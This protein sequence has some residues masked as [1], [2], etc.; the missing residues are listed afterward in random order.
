MIELTLSPYIIKK[1]HEWVFG[2]NKESPDRLYKKLKEAVDNETDVDVKDILNDIFDKLEN[3]VVGDYFKLDKIRKKFDEDIIKIRG[4]EVIRDI[5]IS[6]KD[7]DGKD[8][9]IG[10]KEKKLYEILKKIFVESEYKYFYRSSGWNA[11]LFHQELNLSVCPYCGTQF[12]FLSYEAGGKTRATL[13]HFFD[14]ATYPFLGISVYNLIP[15][16]KVCNYD[17]KGSVSMNL[18][19]NYIPYEKGIVN[20]INFELDNMTNLEMKEK[21]ANNQEIDYYNMF[22]G[23]NEEFDIL[24]SYKEAPTEIAEKIRGN[25]KAFKLDVL[26]NKYHKDYVR[27][28]IKKAYIYNKAYLQNLS[29]TYEKLFENEEDFTKSLFSSVSDD[30]HVILGKLTREIISKELRFHK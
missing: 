18:T 21:A 13:D 19:N 26:Y 12:I 4:K 14:K 24:M 5:K 27:S 15:S 1:H 22:T 2:R 23:A 11:Y 9:Y 28:L 7:K 3:I 20:Y 6:R 10:K 29:T 8:I 25:I 16:C 30:K 17:L